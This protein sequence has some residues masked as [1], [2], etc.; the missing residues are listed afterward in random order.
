MWVQ[1]YAM[2]CCCEETEGTRKQLAPEGK[3]PPAAREVYQV[4]LLTRNSAE[5]A[6]GDCKTE[7]LTVSSPET[8]LALWL[9]YC[10]QGNRDGLQGHG[11][12]SL[13]P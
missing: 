13:L 7:P 5:K 6:S 12:A 9:C 4:K 2:S 10:P 8:P 11:L 1:T 3:D